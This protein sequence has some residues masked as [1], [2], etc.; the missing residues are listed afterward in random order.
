MPSDNKYL[1]NGK[2]LQDEQLGGVNLDWY[3]YGVRYYDPALARWHVVDPA[4]ESMSSW[5]PYNYTFNNPIR[6]I[7]PDGSVPGIPPE[8]IATAGI[9]LKAWA[10]DK[11]GASFNLLS[12]SSGSINAPAGMVPARTQQMSRTLGTI[13]DATSVAQGIVDVGN[14]AATAVGSIPGVETVVDAVGTAAN[15]LQGDL[16]GAAPYAAGLLLPISG[17]QI[18]AGRQGV[19]VVQRAMSKAEL[20]ATKATG[21]LRGGREGTHYVSNSVN[22][23][24]RRAQK[25]LA[26]SG[27]PEL[28]VTMEVPSGAFSDPTKVPPKFGQPGGGM[29]RTATGEVPVRIL[30]EREY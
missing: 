8:L 1:Y 4:A 2:E 24:A 27:K 14:A 6:F 26:L 17:Q 11:L 18:K 19:E 23:S 9:R 16:A 13:S 30:K 10:N 29:E 15:L 7:D 21:L 12:G 5:S 28:K 25:R 3:S 22:N 20:K